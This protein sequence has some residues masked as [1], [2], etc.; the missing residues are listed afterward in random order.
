M[1]I[2][3][4]KN[5][6]FG[7][8]PNHN[9]RLRLFCFPFAGGGASLYC[10]WVSALAPEIEV[11]PIQFPGRENRLREAPFRQFEA[12]I[13]ALTQML[14]PY[15][16]IPYAFFGHSMGALVSFELAHQLRRQGARLPE[17]LFLSAYRSPDTTP[18]E[19]LHALPE[20]ALIKKL[21]ELE[22]TS[23]E[24]LAHAELRQILLP[25][26][27]ADFAVCESYQYIAR[28]P[29]DRPI[30]VLGGDQDK[31][32]RQE[33]LETWR[34]QTSAGFTLYMLPGNHL[35]VRSA[36]TAVLRIVSQTLLPATARTHS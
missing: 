12:L 10:P 31:R 16:D 32:V 20:P 2:A 24:I 36:Q 11:Y 9:A 30:T 1:M 35:F 5:W 18:D 23:Q 21:L 14:Q 25:L 28:E 29:L 19:P 33:A 17:H 15:L 4:T 26:L 22:G 27:R 6:I 13:Q 8:R 34:V 7:T 3:N